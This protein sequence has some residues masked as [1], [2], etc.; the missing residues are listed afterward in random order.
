MDI[1]RIPHGAFLDYFYRDF[2]IDNP[3]EANSEQRRL[4]WARKHP[5]SPQ[6]GGGTSSAT[7][8]QNDRNAPSFTSNKKKSAT[9]KSIANYVPI[10]DDSK[11]KKWIDDVMAIADAEGTP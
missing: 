4:Q 10:T 6:N 3:T 9:K 5:N 2:D 11:F 7:S 1:T 8:S